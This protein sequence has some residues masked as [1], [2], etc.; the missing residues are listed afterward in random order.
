MTILKLFKKFIQY[1]YS[2]YN[3]VVDWILGSKHGWDTQK[4]CLILYSL[5]AYT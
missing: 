5:D 4:D 1:D 3:I 2:I